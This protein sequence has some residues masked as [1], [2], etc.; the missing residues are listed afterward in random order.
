MRYREIK[1]KCVIVLLRYC[2]SVLTAQATHA[3]TH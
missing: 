3:L 1:I 2:V